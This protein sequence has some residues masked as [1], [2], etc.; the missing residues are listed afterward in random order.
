MF[1]FDFP[2]YTVVLQAWFEVKYNTTKY[3]F[4]SFL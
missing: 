1:V 4:L 2:F 3:N